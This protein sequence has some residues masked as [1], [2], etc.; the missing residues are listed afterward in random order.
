M[1]LIKNQA[2]TVADTITDPATTEAY[3]VFTIT[4][5]DLARKLARLTW[6]TILRTYV[7]LAWITDKAVIAWH[8]YQTWYENNAHRQDTNLVS[9]ALKSVA[10]L[11]Q[12]KL[13]D[14]HRYARGQILAT[15]AQQP[16]IE[17][18]IDPNNDTSQMTFAELTAT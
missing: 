18:L 10:L 3:R 15:T 7:V 17:P 2:R 13:I 11:A 16:I 14:L 1:T 5:L 12:G 4:N 6:L 9:E 8:N